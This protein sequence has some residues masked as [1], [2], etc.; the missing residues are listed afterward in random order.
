MDSSSLQLCEW[1]FK[2]LIWYSYRAFWYLVRNASTGNVLIKLHG[3]WF[4][5]H[6]YISNSCYCCDVWWDGLGSSW[7]W[8]KVN[9][10]DRVTLI[11]HLGVKY[12][13]ARQIL[14]YDVCVFIRVWNGVPREVVYVREISQD[15]HVS[16][17]YVML[18]H[19][20]CKTVFIPSLDISASNLG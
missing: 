5:R 9:P 3:K 2:C 19:A 10:T 7:E 17:V 18:I 14:V 15:W 20:F 1:F 8:D 13:T 4:L 12:V 16:F 6:C 11:G